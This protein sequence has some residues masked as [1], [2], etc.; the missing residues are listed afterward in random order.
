MTNT[1]LEYTKKYGV[2]TFGGGGCFLRKIDFVNMLMR[3]LDVVSPVD[4]KNV[5]CD[6]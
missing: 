5:K 1:G 4:K 3:K 6:M 2:A